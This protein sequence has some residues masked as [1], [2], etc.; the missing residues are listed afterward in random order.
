MA[1]NPA[2]NAA[3]ARALRQ[4]SI[5]GSRGPSG[6]PSVGWQQWNDW[7]NGHVDGHWGGTTTATAAGD[8]RSGR[9]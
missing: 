9:T 5:D 8:D 4:G 3:V 2:V 1:D 6:E 7:D